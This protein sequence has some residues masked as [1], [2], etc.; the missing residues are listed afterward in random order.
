MMIGSS[1]TGPGI[2]L[3]EEGLRPDFDCFVECGQKLNWHGGVSISLATC[4]PKSPLW[5]RIVGKCREKPVHEDRNSI[6]H[7]SV[8]S[9]KCRGSPAWYDKASARS[10]QEPLA[11]HHL[12]QFLRA[13]FG[14]KTIR[15]G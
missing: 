6:K 11:D 9:L 13:I 10:I 14:E 1:A 3:V 7:H 12:S 5:G 2:D 15:E 8:R 4:F